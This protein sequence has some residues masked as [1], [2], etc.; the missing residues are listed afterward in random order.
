MKKILLITAIFAATVTFG[1]REE[2]KGHSH[3]GHGHDHGGSCTKE[4]HDHPAPEQE[5]FKVEE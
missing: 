5:S 2:H 1:C 3:G 4:D